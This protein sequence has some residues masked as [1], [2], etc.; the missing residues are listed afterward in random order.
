MKIA[1]TAIAAWV[2]T[3]T[4]GTAAAW[5]DR[6][7]TLI[8]PYAAGGPTDEVARDLAQSLRQGL[9]GQSVV[10]E[11]VTGAGG[12]LGAARVA[13]AAADGYTLL[14]HSSS[15]ATAP[16]LYR[17]LPYRTLE[18]FAYLG[19]IAEVPLALVARPDLPA[20]DFDALRTWIAANR[21]RITIVNAGLGSASWQC[22]LLLQQAL[23]VA[24]TAVPYKGTAPAMTDLL[25]GQV[26]LMCDQTTSTAPQIESGRL[27]AY[28][29]TT[30]KRL[31]APVLARLPS[32]EEAGLKGFDITAWQAL[33]A[34]RG[35]PGPVL[36]TIGTALRRALRDPAFVKREAALG[37]VVVTD[38]RVEGSTH[39]AF[40]A[41]EIERWGPLIRAAGQYAD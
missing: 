41:A 21:G 38:G 39:K 11:N 25:A 22:G 12:T 8:V 19:M 30:P 9:G 28:A 29:V 20:A 2:L 7:V 18:D 34:P 14:I 15:I 1:T 36:E 13:N 6:P 31:T 35:T 27:R 5:P 33:Y 24:M 40:V 3:A 10:I 17:R 32:L 26:D 4:A 23:G 16:A 37:A